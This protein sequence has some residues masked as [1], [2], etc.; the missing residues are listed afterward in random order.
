MENDVNENPESERR[1]KKDKKKGVR[2]IEGGPVKTRRGKKQY[3]PQKRG[4]RTGKKETGSRRRE[5]KQAELLTEAKAEKEVKIITWNQQKAK[6]E[7]K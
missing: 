1:R 3:G 7:T 4:G 2:K 5:W 6:H